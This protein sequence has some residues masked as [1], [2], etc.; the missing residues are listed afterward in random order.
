MFLFSR[1]RSD[2][3][4]GPVLNRNRSFFLESGQEIRPDL[5]SEIAL[6]V[7]TALVNLFDMFSYN[8]WLFTSSAIAW[9]E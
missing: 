8:I 9:L 4:F 5:Y 6:V 1:I 2:S 7:L 3:K